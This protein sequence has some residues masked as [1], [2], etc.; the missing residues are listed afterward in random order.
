MKRQNHGHRWTDPELKSLMA[1]WSEGYEVDL[2]AENLNVTRAA[3][4]KMVLKLRANGIPLA[5]RTKGHFAGRRNKPWTQEEVEY[6]VRRRD[7][8]A[9]TEAIAV[10]LQRSW[11]A[12]QAMV[13]KLRQEGVQVKMLGCGVRRLWSPEKLR[14]SALG[15]GLIEDDAERIRLVARR[16]I[17]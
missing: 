7:Q 4:L 14:E 9:T 2:I 10:E 15:R 1:S 3:V 16:Q 11:A 17:A 6:L 8:Q 13:M 12:V 5:R